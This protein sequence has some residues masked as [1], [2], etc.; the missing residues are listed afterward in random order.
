MMPF[1][2]STAFSKLQLSIEKPD[3]ENRS[4]EAF[5]LIGERPRKPAS[6]RKTGI[7]EEVLRRLLSSPVSLAEMSASGPSLLP[8][9]NDV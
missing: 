8:K 2:L 3:N 1:A 9:R 5:R 6:C 7:T 4:T